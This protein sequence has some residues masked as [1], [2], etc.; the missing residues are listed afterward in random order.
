MKWASW[1]ML[2]DPIVGEAKDLGDSLGPSDSSEFLSH[3]VYC[4]SHGVILHRL[5]IRRF[6]R[7]QNDATSY[8]SYKS[9]GLIV[10]DL[11]ILLILLAQV[12]TYKLLLNCSILLMFLSK[13]PTSWASGLI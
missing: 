1:F 2:G 4:E 3:G 5:P 7:R 9:R 8:Q 10:I 11:L 12:L 6:S 13:F